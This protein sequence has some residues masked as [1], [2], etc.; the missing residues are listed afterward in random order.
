MR[1]AL[2]ISW[3]WLVLLFAARAETMPP[4]PAAYFND[5][6]GVVSSSTARQLNDQLRQFERD[7]SNQIVVAIFR[8]M[9]TS[10]SIEDYTVRIAKS[11]KVGQA[12]RR[13]GAVLFVFTEPH[14]MFIQVGYGLEGA[15]PDILCK[16]I[17]ENEI[18][19]RFKV[20]DYNGGLTAG[21]DAMIKATRGEYHGTGKIHSDDNGQFGGAMIVLAIIL[22][23]VIFSVARAW[24][25]GMVY[26]SNGRGYSSG[27]GGGFW[28]GGGGFWGGG[29]GGGYS[30]GGGGDSGGF[31]GGGG[32]FGGGG[33]GGSW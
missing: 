19:P 26:S 21:V 15:L 20:G 10:S 30:G 25:R 3:L 1:S 29:G 33:A 14:K 2:L 4:K 28:G 6:A 32:D 9:D 11:W 13:N 5:Y 7:S 8:K 18:T 22:I 27:G 12:D 17:I 16:Q 31:S 24:R 23:Y